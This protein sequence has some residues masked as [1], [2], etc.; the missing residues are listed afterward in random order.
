MAKVVLLLVPAL[1]VLYVA[2][3]M[4]DSQSIPKEILSAQVNGQ[5]RYMML[6]AQNVMEVVTQVTFQKFSRKITTT[7]GKF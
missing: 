6:L 4:T 7:T 3:Y 1:S 2:G 5:E